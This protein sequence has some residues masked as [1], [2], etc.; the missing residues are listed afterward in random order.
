MNKY[1]TSQIRNI[2]LVGAKGAGKT[3]FV[4]SVLFTA[5]LT[6]RIGRVDEG[7]S[8]VDYDSLEIERKQSITS[9]LIVTEWEKTKINLIDTPGYSDFIGEVVGAVSAADVIL[10][11]I[12]SSNGVDIAAKRLFSIVSEF[13]KPFAFFINKM[14]SERADLESSLESIKELTSGIALFQLPIGTG[15]DFKGTINLLD[16]SANIPADLNDK[17]KN[18]KTELMEAIAESDEALLEKY[19]EQGS[20]SEQE[21]TSAVSKGIALGQTHPVYL[22]SSISAAGF[23]SLLNSMV[24]DCPSPDLL[25]PVK[26]KRPDNSE[27]ELTS[28]ANGPLVA[29]VFKTTS[30]PGIGDIFFFRVWSG[31]AK[32]GGDVYNANHNTSER[33]GHIIVTRGKERMEIAEAPAGDIG[34]VAKLKSTTINNTFTIK[35]N[36]F[37]CNQ[38]SFPKPVVPM[39]VKPKTK[40]DQDK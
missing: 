6:S 39:A 5:K 35:N 19:L 17:V 12:D 25:P 27:I 37:V 30:D 10:F 32:S 16:S 23:D 34:A 20:I 18:L 14:D 1:Q 26:V 7:N 40:K 38:I 3:S 24:R 11:V 36:T 2:V 22:G 15:A 9:K 13:N 8:I 21:M 4:E 28:D 29:Q 33:M 31:T